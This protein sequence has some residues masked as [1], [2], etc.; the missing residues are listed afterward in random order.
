MTRHREGKTQRQVKNKQA[1]NEANQ[2][3]NATLGS[4]DTPELAQWE[5][6]C[7]CKEGRY[8]NLSAC[9]RA[10]LFACLHV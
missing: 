7:E 1:N 9:F 5:V 8:T 3:I 6:G 10:W 4:C 2:I